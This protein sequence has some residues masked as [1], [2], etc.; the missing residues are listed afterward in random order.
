MIG[1]MWI[2]EM[3]AESEEA[4]DKKDIDIIRN[5]HDTIMEMYSHLVSVIKE[6]TGSDDTEDEDEIMEFM[7]E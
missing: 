1:A 2:F 4:A 6:H 7:P 3:A 5:N